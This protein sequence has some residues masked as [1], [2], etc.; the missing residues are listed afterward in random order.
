M[1]L[2]LSLGKSEGRNLTARL[3]VGQGY[4]SHRRVSPGTCVR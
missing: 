3:I 2:F 1:A 4:Q